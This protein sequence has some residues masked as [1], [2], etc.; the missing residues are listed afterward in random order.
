MAVLLLG[1]GIVT[2][3]M[4]WTDPTVLV[5]WV[6][7]TPMVGYFG[8]R[9]A[10]DVAAGA[11]GARAFE[12]RVVIVGA[13]APGKRF[14]TSLTSVPGVAFC[15][16]S[17]DRSIVRVGVAREELL[18]SEAEVPGFCQTGRADVVY[19]ALPVMS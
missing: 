6:C 3:K 15:G 19:V 12:R 9:L 8:G 13:N 18:G 1:L 17:N 7:L 4:G 11:V 14:R 5:A 10:R 2:E 16:F